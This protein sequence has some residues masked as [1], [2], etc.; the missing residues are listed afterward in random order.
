M[1]ISIEGT[2]KNKLLASQESTGDSPVLPAC[3]LLRNP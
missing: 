2:G 3:S 1:L